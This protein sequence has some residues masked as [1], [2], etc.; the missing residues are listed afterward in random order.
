MGFLDFQARQPHTYVR[1]PLKQGDP[2]TVNLNLYEPSSKVVPPICPM[3]RSPS[4][5]HR[6]GQALAW[7]C[8]WGSHR[9]G[10]QVWGCRLIAKPPLARQG[11][12]IF[13]C[14]SFIATFRCEASPGSPCGLPHDWDPRHIGSP[15]NRC[16]CSYVHHRSNSESLIR[17]LANEAW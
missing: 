14:R 17:F 5:G 8:S 2:K 15:D 11:F 16:S 6:S 4:A 1:F 7:V 13:S 9:S 10:V 12:H 3:F